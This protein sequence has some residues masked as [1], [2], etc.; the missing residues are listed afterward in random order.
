[1]GGEHSSS[2]PGVEVTWVPGGLREFQLQMTTNLAQETSTILLRSGILWVKDSGPRGTAC[3][4]YTSSGA[5]AGELQLSW[6]E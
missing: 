1:M 2:G 3:L 4:C 6:G 5:S